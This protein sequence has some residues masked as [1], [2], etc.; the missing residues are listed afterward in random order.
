[1]RRSRTKERMR[2]M[3]K[4]NGRKRIIIIITN[5]NNELLTVF[6]VTQQ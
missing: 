4:K 2:K 1:M 6:L 5:V 3:K